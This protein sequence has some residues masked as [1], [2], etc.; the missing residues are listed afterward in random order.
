MSV[1]KDKK[2]GT[3]KV[4]Y[5]YTD[6]Q[7]KVHQSTKRGFSTKKSALEWERDF[8]NKNEGN[9]NMTFADFVEIYLV[10]RTSFKGKYILYQRTDYKNKNITVFR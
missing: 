5:R 10:E 4:C 3:W 9:L 8:C 7:G 2:T 6:W 1:Y